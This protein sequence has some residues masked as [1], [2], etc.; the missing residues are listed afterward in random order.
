MLTQALAAGEL[1]DIDMHGCRP[2]IFCIFSFVIFSQ[3]MRW[4]HRP[5]S[6]HLRGAP[7]PTLDDPAHPD[8]LCQV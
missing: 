2:L 7:P 3:D 8:G 6:T 1:F 5:K 4:Q